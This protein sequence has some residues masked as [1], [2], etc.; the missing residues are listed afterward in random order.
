ML[1]FDS[2]NFSPRQRAD[3]WETFSADKLSALRCVPAG[4]SQFRVRA[5]IRAVGELTMARITGA[6][7]VSERT[8]YEVARE[9]HGYYAA[10][11]HLE[12]EPSVGCRKAISQPRVRDVSILGSMENMR[13]G[14]ERPYDHIVVMLPQRLPWSQVA[15]PGTVVPASNPLLG[16]L[17]DYVVSVHAHA[18][19]LSSSSADLLAD[20]LTEL[21]FAMLSEEQIRVSTSTSLR[22]ALFDR[23]CR[24]IAHEAHDPD[25]Y[26]A[27]VAR[28]LGVSMRMLQRIFREHGQT[29]AHGILRSR[30]D[31]GSSMLGDER[32]RVRTITEIAFECG[33]R[34]LTTF[35]RAFRATKGMTPS[36]WRRGASN[37]E[38]ADQ[39]L[40]DTQIVSDWTETDLGSPASPYS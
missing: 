11:F 16:I 14:L 35:E 15:I 29:V 1:V 33:F 25:L 7:H 3:A 6:G 4:D 34:D 24:I 12:G 20:N 10:V 30:V 37:V 31:K 21:L 36:S 22:A 2:N 38:W 19:R 18:D 39:S 17:C 40:M 32:M 9:R 8:R 13:F 23:A 28:Q 5:D 26:P 27:G